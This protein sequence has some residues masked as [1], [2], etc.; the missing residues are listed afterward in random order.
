M[1]VFAGLEADCLARGD[2]DLSAGAGIASYA[3]LAGLDGEDAEAA[4]LDTIAFD[5]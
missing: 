2:G 3:G 5:E 4:K 1:K